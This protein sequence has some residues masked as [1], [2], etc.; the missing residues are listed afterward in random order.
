M[1]RLSSPDKAWLSAEVPREL[2][3]RFREAAS[4]ADRSAAQ[5]LRHLVRGR[6]AKESKACG[7]R[8]NAKGSV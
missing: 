5:E 4:A 3:D 8:L 7:R 6:V 1:P 2:A